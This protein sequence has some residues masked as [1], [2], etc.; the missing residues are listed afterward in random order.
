MRAATRVGRFRDIEFTWFV[1]LSGAKNLLSSVNHDPLQKQI[2]RL[3]QND[4]V[5]F[6]G[7]S[8]G[9]K[10]NLVANMPGEPYQYCL[11]GHMPGQ[12]PTF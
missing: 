11:S 10:K 7:K 1:I 2:L 6:F 9:S 12:I 8:L 5:D 3:A 4:K